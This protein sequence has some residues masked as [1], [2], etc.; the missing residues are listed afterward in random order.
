MT[1]ATDE[2][3]KLLEERGLSCQTSYLHTS[4]CV[5]S[6]LYEAVDNFD[7]TLT[8]DNLTPEQAIAATLDNEV[9]WRSVALGLLDSLEKADLEAAQKWIVDN[10]LLR[11]ELAYGDAIAVTLG[12]TCNN[13]WAEFGKFRCSECWTQVDAISTNTTQPMPIR[14]CPNCGRKIVTP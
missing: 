9:G 12:K 10:D 7:G 6:K 4:W 14:Y 11:E 1:S 3:L 8:V 2:L 5:G 13:E